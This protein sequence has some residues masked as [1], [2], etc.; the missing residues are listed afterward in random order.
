MEQFNNE[1]KIPKER[2]AV[3][4]GKNGEIKRELEEK[5][6]VKLDIDSTE[7]IVS[8]SGNEAINV[9]Q[10][11][12]IVKAIARGFNP[13]I[14]FLLLKIDYMFEIINILDFTASKDQL[15]RLKG[16]VI[17][18]N[19][20]SRTCIEE[21]TETHISV[22]GKTVGIIGE[23]EYVAIARKALESLLNGSPHSNV[24]HWLEKQRKLVKRRE[25]EEDINTLIIKSGK[26]KSDPDENASSGKDAKAAVVFGH[27]KE[28]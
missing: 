11:L 27:E 3:I 13:E 26:K 16:R 4:I 22:Y 7:G 2:V 23:P 12:E 17:G 24:Y 28:E 1:I 25:F 15:A 8:I 20:K 19:G 9:F 18:Q 10:C 6:G 21:L 14:A 5:T